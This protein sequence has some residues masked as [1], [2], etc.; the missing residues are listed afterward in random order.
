MNRR[1]FLTA[2]LALV[3]VNPSRGCAEPRK[4]K[5]FRF[6]IKTKNGGVVGNVTIEAYD[7]EAAKV[8]LK[9]RYPDCEILNVS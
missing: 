7:V 1:S 3:L 2:A 5:K 6:R 9:K 8:K 4:L